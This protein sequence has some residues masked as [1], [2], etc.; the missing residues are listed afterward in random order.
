MLP[1]FCQTV[2]IELTSSIFLGIYILILTSLCNL[3]NSLLSFVISMSAKFCFVLF[4]FSLSNFPLCVNHTVVSDSEAPGT[5][6]H[7]APLFM[8]FS[9][10]EHWSQLLFPSPGDLPNTGIKPPLSDRLFTTGKANLRK[11]TTSFSAL[12]CNYYKGNAQT[13]CFF[14]SEGHAEKGCY[15]KINENCKNTCI[16]QRIH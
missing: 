2:E 1:M 10:Q 12:L 14:T 3:D 4:C 7:H 15:E 9:Q 16:V 6:A 5:V 13:F 11:Y 8:G